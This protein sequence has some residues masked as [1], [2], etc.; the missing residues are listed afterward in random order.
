MKLRSRRNTFVSVS[1]LRT[2]TRSR[3]SYPVSFPR[4]Y[5]F[6]ALTQCILLL[7]T[8]PQCLL[9]KSWWSGLLDWILLLKSIWFSRPVKRWDNCRWHVTSWDM[10]I[11]MNFFRLSQDEY[12]FVLNEEDNPLSFYDV[13][14]DDVILIKTKWNSALL[15]EILSAHATDLWWFYM[16][17]FYCCKE[18]KIFLF[19]IQM[20]DIAKKY[21]YIQ[22]STCI[23][24][25]ERIELMNV[26]LRWWMMMWGTAGLLLRFSV[27]YIT[28]CWRPA[29]WTVTGDCR[30]RCSLLQS[31]SRSTLFLE[32]CISSTHRL[33]VLRR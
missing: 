8:R 22:F 6:D 32:T 19:L 1:W 12:E 33:W 7:Q 3:R 5:L 10:I 31:I 25:I 27:A 23:F 14:N 15:N 29:S 20:W 11:D 18:Q 30:V 28:C 26:M 13:G 24:V 4:P 21:D 17:E 9:L 16:M 2:E